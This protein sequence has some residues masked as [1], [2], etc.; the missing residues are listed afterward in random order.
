MGILNNSELKRL[1]DLANTNFD[2]FVTESLNIMTKMSN[3]EL[4]G[5]ETS[6]QDKLDILTRMKEY[7]I[8]KED[9]EK[10]ALVVEI[11]KR[12]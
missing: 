3:K 11:E 8:E 6:K 7:L 5:G 12:L 2:Q 9:Y 4:R 10:C 1:A